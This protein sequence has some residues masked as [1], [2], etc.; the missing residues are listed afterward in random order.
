LG[1]VAQGGFHVVTDV[2]KLVKDGGVEVCDG[3]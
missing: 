3:G 2:F 1:F